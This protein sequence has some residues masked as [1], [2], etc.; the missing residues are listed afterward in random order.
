MGFHAS[1]SSSGGGGGSSSSSN[2]SS[3]SSSS[4]SSSSSSSISMLRARAFTL[5]GWP[6]SCSVRGTKC[7]NLQGFC[8]AGMKMSDLGHE[9]LKGELLAFL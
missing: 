4:N 9:F 2:S 8:C 5:V 6:T 1:S 3:S 7:C